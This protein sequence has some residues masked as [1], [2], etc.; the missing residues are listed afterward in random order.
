MPFFFLKL[1]L[2]LFFPVL[3]FGL[4]KGVGEKPLTIPEVVGIKYLR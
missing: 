4:Y 2:N 1:V 3:V